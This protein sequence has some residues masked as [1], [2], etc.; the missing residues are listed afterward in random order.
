M[1][2]CVK[3]LQLLVTSALSVA[4]VPY[5][6][7]H[8]TPKPLL[9]KLTFS[10]F[11]LEQ[12]QCIFNQYPSSDIWL[13]VALNSIIPQ[14]N[15][16]QLA[17][18]APYSSFAT[19]QY[20]HILKTRG[21]DY[22]CSDTYGAMVA[23]MSVGSEKDCTDIAFCNGLLPLL[24]SYRVKFVVL[25]MNSSVLMV[26]SRWSEVIILQTGKNSSEI[27]P[28]PMRRSAGMIIITVILSVLLAILLACLIAALATGSKDICWRRKINN[29]AFATLEMIF[30]R[31]HKHSV[32]V[33]HSQHKLELVWKHLGLGSLPKVADWWG[34]QQIEGDNSRW[35][36]IF[37]HC[38]LLPDY[39]DIRVDAAMLLGPAK[40]ALYPVQLKRHLKESCKHPGVSMENNY[41]R[42]AGCCSLKQKDQPCTA[43][44]IKRTETR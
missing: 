12:P 44:R 3:L 6:V 27:D 36:H 13:V 26:G 17:T 15:D 14:L 29:E 28:W 18:P 7:P 2:L 5:Y 11:V 4:D 23:M 20:Y 43:E 1:G 16:T 42:L 39:T 21:S 37:P 33:E 24:G 34:W 41:N 40:K 32:Y 8:I 38:I 9:G 22:P 30:N 31:Y 10:G 19:N 25:D 35:W